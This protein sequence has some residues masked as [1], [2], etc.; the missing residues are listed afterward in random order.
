MWWCGVKNTKL[1]TYAH[2]LLCTYYTHMLLEKNQILFISSVV[3]FWTNATFGR[4]NYKK[5]ALMDILNMMSSFRWWKNVEKKLC[6]AKH[7]D[8]KMIDINLYYVYYSFDDKDDTT[9]YCLSS[10]RS[11]ISVLF[12]GLV[13]KLFFVCFLFLCASAYFITILRTSTNKFPNIFASF[14]FHHSGMHW[15]RWQRMIFWLI[16]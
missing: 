1:R 7:T 12:C 3:Y 15:C 9:A 16:N 14:C 8:G 11:V 5:E 6:G 4:R 2:I 10:S 13:K